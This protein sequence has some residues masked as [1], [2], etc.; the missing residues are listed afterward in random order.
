MAG[1]DAYHA[2]NEAFV[3]EDYVTALKCY[4]DAL[5]AEPDN[6][7]YYK[8]RACLHLRQENYIDA[9][10]DASRA[11]KLSADAK[12]Y[13]RKG[14][15][16]FQMHEFEESSIAFRKAVEL[17]PESKELKRWLRKSEVRWLGTRALHGSRP[18]PPLSV[19]PG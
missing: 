17:E 10:A 5:A 12:T 11:I 16:L 3:D 2:G 9:V 4:S 14:E 18:H 15:A 6:A 8:K 19:I 13:Q 1:L 7:K